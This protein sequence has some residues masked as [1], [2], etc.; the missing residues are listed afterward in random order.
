MAL[1][2]QLKGHRIETAYDGENGL[3][4]ADEFHPDFI[5]LDIGLPGISG[6][7]VARSIRKQAWGTQPVLIA[8]T[9]WG[10]YEDR[11]KSKDAGFDY[12]WT[13]P[14]D[15]DALDRLLVQ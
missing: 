12:H 8:M 5:L 1:Q 7:D 11:T 4:L 9:G 2:L 3:V 6:H 13:K 14:V 15:P 10:Q